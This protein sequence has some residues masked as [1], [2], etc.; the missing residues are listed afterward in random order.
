MLYFNNTVVSKHKWQSVNIIFIEKIMALLS[1]HLFTFVI[2]FSLDN[3]SLQSSDLENYID[4]DTR[5]YD[6]GKSLS[7]LGRENE[8][9]TVYWIFLS[10]FVLLVL[11]FLIYL[12]ANYFYFSPEE[13]VNLRQNCEL[14]VEF[15]IAV[16]IYEVFLYY[17]VKYMQ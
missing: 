5:Y 12:V 14:F 17:L 9:L 3:L 13:D 11:C 2:F 10:V 7:D 15:V 4:D 6:S 1:R 16:I 8:D